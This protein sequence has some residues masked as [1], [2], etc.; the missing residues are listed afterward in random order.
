[1]ASSSYPFIKILNIRTNDVSEFDSDD[2]NDWLEVDSIGRD[3]DT[4][5]FA[6]YHNHI[7]AG[8]GKG[9]LDYDGR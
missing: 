7:E 2:L 3:I 4:F 5:W 1:M 6:V 8:R 9:M